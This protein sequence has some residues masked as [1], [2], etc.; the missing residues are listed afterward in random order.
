M[1]VGIDSEQMARS[2]QNRSATTP[3]TNTLHV[4]I[5]FLRT[6]TDPSHEFI[7][8]AL[9]ASGVVFDA[10]EELSWHSVPSHELVDGLL[11]EDPDALLLDMILGVSTHRDVVHG[12]GT[13]SLPV[14]H[15]SKLQSQAEKLINQLAARDAARS[16][17]CIST[18]FEFSL[19]LAQKVFS[20]ENLTDHVAAFFNFVHSHFPIIH[21]PTFD[22]TSVSSP[23]LLAISLNGSVHCIPKDDAL[24]A[25]NFSA[26]AEEYVFGLLQE[27]VMH[28]KPLEGEDW[29]QVMQAA[30]MMHALRT[31][32]NNEHIRCSYRIKRHPTIITCAR[33]LGLIGAKHADFEELPDWDTF[34]AMETR[35]R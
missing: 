13:Q 25:R 33:I 20:I 15:M 12:P 31:N 26:L 2:S 23:L 30:L 22:I 18:E 4:P 3:E 34:I 10:N 24:S 5:S 9:V 35:V 28:R 17:T 27:L 14:Q 32:I 16:K 1:D 21:R 19:P 6:Y 8:D 7:T 29:I 11:H